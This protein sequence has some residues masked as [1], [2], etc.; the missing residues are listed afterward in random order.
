LAGKMSYWGPGLILYRAS[1]FTVKTTK[2]SISEN[3]S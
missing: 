1:L 3:L 2:K